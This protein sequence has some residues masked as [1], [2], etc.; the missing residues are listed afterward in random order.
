MFEIKHIAYSIFI[1]YVS[2]ISIH[3]LIGT[4][5]RYIIAFTF[6][7]IAC[8]E[9]L[10]GPRRIHDKNPPVTQMTRENDWDNALI[11]SVLAFWF[12]DKFTTL[13]ENETSNIPS[14]FLYCFGSHYLLVEPIYYLAHYC[15]HKS[16]FYSHRHHHQSIVTMARSGTSHPLVENI[17]YMCNFSLPFIVPALIG[18]FSRYTIIPYFLFFDILNAIGHCNFE[19]MPKFMFDAPFKYFIYNSQYH[20][21]HHRL[22]TV[23]MCL[24][25]PIWDIIFG[26]AVLSV[27]KEPVKQKQLNAVFLGHNFGLNSSYMNIK[28]VQISGSTGVTKRNLY[29]A[30]VPLNYII[31]A[32]HRILRYVIADR[33]SF[34]GSKI[35]IWGLPLQPY[36]FTNQKEYVNELIIRSI[37]DASKK[38]V[39][40][41]GLGALNKA[42]FVNNSGADLIDYIPK[43][44]YLVHGNTLTAALAWRAIMKEVNK[45]KHNRVAIIGSRSNIG[46]AITE[47]LKLDNVDVLTY[48]FIDDA[49]YDVLLSCSPVKIPIPKHVTIVDVCVPSN[50]G[51]IEN[52]IISPCDI[53]IPEYNNCDLTYSLTGENNVMPACLLATCLHVKEGLAFN[54]L[55][56][57]D[58]SKFEFWLQLHDKLC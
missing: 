13:F 25:C 38:G 58:V 42:S 8:S 4:M 10:S 30:F 55:G 51:R 45:S 21:N 14:A 7:L 22:F 40:H 41:V 34:Y 48:P 1:V 39:T 20:A 24:F 29:Y 27:F 15:M 43:G 46:S 36:D 2:N 9:S 56:K 26:T 23:N 17:Y 57:I 54:E 12:V 50:K 3:V 5:A 31:L 49:A 6:N 32:I 44:V 19:A 53:I 16:N 33:F 35:E 47:R 37:H 11:L 28:H 18:E 52:K